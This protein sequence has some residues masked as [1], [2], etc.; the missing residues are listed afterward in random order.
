[1][2]VHASDKHLTEANSAKYFVR[3]DGSTVLKKRGDLTEREVGIVQR[4]IKENYLDMYKIW[5]DFGGK[6]FY[7]N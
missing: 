7:K 5:K 2:H 3:D 6:G 1:M 4:F